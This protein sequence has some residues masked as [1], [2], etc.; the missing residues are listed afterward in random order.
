MKRPKAFDDV[1][2]I[3]R[4]SINVAMGSIRSRLDRAE[5]RFGID[6]REWE[7][8]EMGAMIRQLDFYVAQE[9]RL[10]KNSISVPADWWAAL[11]FRW[12]PRWWLERWPVKMTTIETIVEHY[13]TCPH[14]NIPPHHPSHIEFLLHESIGSL[15]PPEKKSKR[16]KP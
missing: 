13:H 16:G 14:I 2:D 1:M 11:K 3:R 6:L 9:R 4:V 10:V 7:E 12:F 15:L 8:Y 5:M